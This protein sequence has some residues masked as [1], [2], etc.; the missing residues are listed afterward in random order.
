[1]R[2]VV[3]DTNVLVVA[4]RQAPQA[5]PGCVIATVDALQQIQHHGR[6][7]LDTGIRIL[8]EYMQQ[9]L[10]FSGQP[11]A[12]DAFFKWVFDN[13]ANAER[14][15]QVEIHP[16]SGSEHDFEEFPD[17]PVLENF[18]RS[19]RKFVAVALASHNDPDILNAVDS[20]W[21]IYRQPLTQHGVNIQLLCPEQFAN[22]E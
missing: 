19:D 4:N 9:G 16:K 21:W 2:V 13:Q 18:D 5:G 7:A 20:D 8:N 14:C 11:G 12:G 1:M 6:I 17:D 22:E 10:S 3:V 15:E